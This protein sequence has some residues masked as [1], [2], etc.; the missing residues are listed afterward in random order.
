MQSAEIELK[1]PVDD[2]QALH[3]KLDELGFQV[4]TPR[5][6]EQNTLYDTPDRSLKAGGQLLRVRQ[7]G[8]KFVVTHKRHPDDEEPDSFYKVRIETESEV[9]DGPALAEIFT[10]IGYGPTFR[11]EKYRT[12]YSHRDAPGAHLVVDETP[13]GNY[14]ELEGPTGWIDRTLNALGVDP[15]VCLTESY[16][17]LFLAWKKRTGSPVENLTFAEIAPVLVGA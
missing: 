2:L 8:D 17:K 15:G 3:D 4:D 14:A 5:T 13:I 1:L 12:E 10:R 9:A 16:G 11:Y 7:Y 6:F